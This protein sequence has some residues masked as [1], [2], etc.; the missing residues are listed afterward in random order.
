MNNGRR[1]DRD[2]KIFKIFPLK[3][4]T[5]FVFLGRRDFGNVIYIDSKLLS[6]LFMLGEFVNIHFKM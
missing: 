3:E 5:N 4:S 6:L 1:R 2:D